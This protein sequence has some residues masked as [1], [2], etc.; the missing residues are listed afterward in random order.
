ML[1]RGVIGH[2]VQDDLEV[3]LVGLL[4]QSV[5]VC[6]GSEERMDI[7]V[8][9]NIIAKIAHRRRIDGG[10]PESVNAEPVQVVQLPHNTKKISHAVP[11]A[12]EKT[13]WVDLINHPRLPPGVQMRHGLFCSSSRRLFL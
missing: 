12:I 1:I 4:K 6:Q 9:A 2:K 8:I 7:G 5:Q 3:M 11:I 13:A 10:E